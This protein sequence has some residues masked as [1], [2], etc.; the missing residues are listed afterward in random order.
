MKMKRLCLTAAALASAGWLAAQPRFLAEKPEQHLGE[1]L[2]QAPKTIVYD[3]QN[4][5]TQP[6]VIREVRPSCGCIQVTYPRDPIPAGGKGSVTALYDAALMGTFYRELA[7][8]TNAGDQPVYL[9]FG[10]RVTEK[11][12][13]AIDFDTHFPI[14]LGDIRLSTNSIEF[15]DVNKGDQPVAELQVVNMS[16]D[17]YT[18]QLM[19]LPA[20]LKAEYFPQVLHKGRTGRIRLTLDSGKLMMNGLNQTSIYM[21][22]QMGDRVGSDN[23]IVVSAV[24]LPA[25]AKLTASQLDRAPRIVMLDGEEMVNAP[26]PGSKPSGTAEINFSPAGRK[27]K[28]TKTIQVTNIGEEPLTVQ[29]VQV[30]NRAVS[31]SLDNR[32]IPARGTSRLKITVDTKLLRKAKNKPRV[33]LICNDPRQAKTVLNLNVD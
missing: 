10:G 27:T 5:G 12:V 15:D 21:A 20:Y 31:V 4:T 24:L 32:L 6:L 25:F 33:L 3:F 26:T 11:A 7:V 16:R 22:R 2:F 17:R 8:Y 29:S 13:E 14:D 18:P 23:E 28:L 30:F 19:H 9:S 1:L